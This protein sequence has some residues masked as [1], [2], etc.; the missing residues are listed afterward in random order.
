MALT[1]NQEIEAQAGLAETVTQGVYRYPDLLNGWL[2][3]A[4]AEAQREYHQQASQMTVM[5]VFYPAAVNDL[6]GLLKNQIG[7]DSGLTTDMAN[8]A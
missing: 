6:P 2:L 7:L 4:Q 8:Q 5:V 3:H 1:V